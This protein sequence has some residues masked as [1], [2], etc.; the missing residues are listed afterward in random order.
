MFDVF[1]SYGVIAI[2][3]L[4]GEFVGKIYFKERHEF[5]RKLIHVLG[6]LAAAVLPGFLSLNAIA[7]VAATCVPFMLLVR[8]KQVLGGLYKVDRKSWGEVFFP[9]GVAFSALIAQ[10]PEAY[11]FAMI[12]LTFSDTAAAYFGL[13][14]AKK[15]IKVWGNKKSYIGSSALFFSVIIL[16]IATILFS[17]GEITSLVKLLI[18]AGFCTLAELCSTN[19]LDNITLPLIATLSWNL[20]V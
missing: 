6:G 1:I 14:Y 19:G 15:Y 4:V 5:T 18:V 12:V 11:V 16:A 8:S 20:L 3:L 7:V 9:V 17:G 13:R 2:S 10:T